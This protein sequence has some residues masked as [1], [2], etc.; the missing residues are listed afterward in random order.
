MG[1]LL[2]S[3]LCRTSG[4][5]GPHLVAQ[6][7]LPL[8]GC[9][10]LPC[11]ICCYISHLY[12]DASRSWGSGALAYLNWFRI[13]WQRELPVP[14]IIFKERLPIVVAAAM[15]GYRWQGTY[16]LCR[17]LGKDGH[18]GPSKHPSCTGWPHSTPALLSHCLPG[19]S[20]LLDLSR[21]HSWVP[22][23]QCR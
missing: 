8:V 13:Q 3:K 21:P 6:A 15:W 18:S 1:L 2:C 10:S 12:T 7:M 9:L 16:I 14:S 20:R 11:S 22:Q 19:P 17:P 4:I 5:C 23:H